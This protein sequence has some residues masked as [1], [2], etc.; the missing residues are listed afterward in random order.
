MELGDGGTDGLAERVGELGRLSGEGEV[1][2]GCVKTSPLLHC[3]ARRWVYTFGAAA[4]ESLP[5][6][7]TSV[8]HG[9]SDG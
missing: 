4:T 5:E 2:V 7:T 3:H 9:I 8:S 6:S 1:S